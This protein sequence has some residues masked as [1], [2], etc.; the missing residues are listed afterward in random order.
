MKLSHAT[1]VIAYGSKPYDGTPG[2][3]IR[4]PNMSKVYPKFFFDSFE[5]Q[6]PDHLANQLVFFPVDLLRLSWC[7][8]FW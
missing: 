3:Q 8:F 7:V 5:S 4:D 2:S 6:F 1:H